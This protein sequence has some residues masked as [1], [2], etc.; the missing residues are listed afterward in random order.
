MTPVRHIFVTTIPERLEQGVIY[1]SVPYATVAH[2]CACGCGQEVNLPL[3]PTDWA[4]VYDGETI[5]L[6]PSVGNWSLPCQSHYYIRNDAV[7]W[8]KAWTKQRIAQ[9]RQTDQRR[10]QRFFERWS[11]RER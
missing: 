10:K 2:L 1:V 4:L 5:S 3:S 7:V 6:Y 11:K 9:G 8:A